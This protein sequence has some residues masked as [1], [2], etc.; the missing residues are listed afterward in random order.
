[1]DRGGTLAIAGI[2]LSDIPA[3]NYQ[4]HLFQERQVRSVTSNTRND[5]R[6]FL[7][8]AGQHHLQVTTPEYPLDRADE[9]LTDLSAGR[10]AGAAVLR[11]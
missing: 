11:V 1:L 5:A 6:E 10:I 2:H 4:R 9:A 7:A 3:L 8:F